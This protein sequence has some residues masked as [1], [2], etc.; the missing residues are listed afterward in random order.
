[1]KT[2]TKR[3]QTKRRK[4]NKAKWLLLAFFTINALTALTV[5]YTL[6]VIYP[7]N[8]MYPQARVV[9]QEVKAVDSIESQLSHETV[10][11]TIR[12]LAKEANFPWADFLVRLANCESRLNPLAVNTQNNKPA[13]SKDRGL[14]QISD[15]WHKE[16]SDEV[17]F[18]VELS[19]KWAME[20]ITNGGQGIWVCNKY[21][22]K[23]PNKYNP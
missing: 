18:S 11:Q 23:N 22:L 7:K 19:T 3:Y 6:D 2:K 1:M 13:H 8:E 10:E 17:A 4:N 9:R 12:R 5:P 20:K 21:V 15:Y 16:V 14:F